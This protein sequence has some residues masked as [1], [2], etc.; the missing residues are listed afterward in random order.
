MK[1]NEISVGSPYASS[2]HE[3]KSLNICKAYWMLEES[4]MVWGKNVE[5]MPL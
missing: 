3:N 1:E 4:I 5:I 2:N